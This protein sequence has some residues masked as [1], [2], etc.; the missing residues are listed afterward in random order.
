MKSNAI[1]FVYDITNLD[2]FEEMKKMYNEVKQNLDITKIIT[3]VVGNKNDQYNNEAVKKPVAE[4]YAKSIKAYFRI[5]SA[6]E[7]QG[8]TE[9]FDYIAGLFLHKEIKDD[10]ESKDNEGGK[11]EFTLNKKNNN[12][13]N[14]NKKNGKCC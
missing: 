3:F 13:K 7:N 1:I 5:V 12:N 9:I 10:K 11:K 6:L 2:S 14:D 8:I 4:Q